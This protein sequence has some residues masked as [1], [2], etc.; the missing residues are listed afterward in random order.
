MKRAAF[1]KSRIFL[2][3]KGEFEI[4]FS[5]LRLPSTMIEQQKYIRRKRHRCSPDFEI[6]TNKRKSGGVWGS[7]L[8][9]RERREIQKRKNQKH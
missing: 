8:R 9:G 1:L 7:S 3:T 4:N 2:E 5:I 6:D